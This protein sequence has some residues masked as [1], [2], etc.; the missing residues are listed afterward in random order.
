MSGQPQVLR[1]AM[2]DDEV[3]LS[4]AVRRILA[5]YRVSVE[6]VGVDVV[7]ATA[8]FGDGEHFLESLAGGAEYDLLL[9]D[10]KLPGMNGLDILTELGKQGHLLLT[11]MVT[12]YATFETAVQATKLGAYDFLPSLSHQRSS[13]TRCAKPPIS[14]SSAARPAGSPKSSAKCAS[15]SSPCSRT[16]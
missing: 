3:P 10:L 6:A 12:A 13:A 9:L 7:Y 14:S 5:K 16:S 1:V 2:V 15:T 11:I 8:H 4:L